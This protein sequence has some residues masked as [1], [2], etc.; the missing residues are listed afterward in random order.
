[1]PM[2]L[3]DKIEVISVEAL[4]ARYIE[5]FV[6]EEH[7]DLLKYIYAAITWQTGSRIE[8]KKIDEL[9]SPIGEQAQLQN[10]GSMDYFRYLE[11]DPLSFRII[12]PTESE[13]KIIEESKKYKRFPMQNIEGRR[14]YFASSKYLN[15]LFI[16][17]VRPIVTSS[18]S[19]E[20]IKLIR[21]EY[22]FGVSIY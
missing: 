14:L 16:G 4:D 5:T 2:S 11:L 1:M 6:S 12:K 8:I 13:Q 7:I 22:N 17:V 18:L 21:I 10:L 9:L 20:G 3:E 15:T 19:F